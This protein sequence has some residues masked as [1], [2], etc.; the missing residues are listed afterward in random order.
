MEVSSDLIHSADV[1]VSGTHTGRTI[2]SFLLFLHFFALAVGL[3]SNWYPSSLAAKLRDVP[4]VEPYLGT[5]GLD[6]SYLERYRLTHALPDDTEHF[7]D[8]ELTLA[9][10]TQRKIRLGAGDVTPPQ[11]YRRYARLADTSARL[12]GNPSLESILPQAVAA[13]LLAE[14]GATG[15]T[16]R[17]H[18]RYLQG[19]QSIDSPIAD[20]RDPESELYNST[21][22]EARI[23][24]AG[25]Q[26]QLLKTEAAS[27]AAPA[28]T[29][30]VTP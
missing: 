3:I 21:L 7:I 29:A 12:V 27:D 9:D 25:G 30:P 1:P 26:V 28:A 11:R 14:H 15:G 16:I 24:K 2:V 8:A 22:Y 5:L 17:V 6:L 10:G 4:A 23:L 19:P 20:E 13:G 18:R